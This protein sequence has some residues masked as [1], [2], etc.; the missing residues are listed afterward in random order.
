M[1]FNDELIWYENY[2]GERVKWENYGNSINF[3]MYTD[4]L[5]RFRSF[6]IKS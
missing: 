4:H 1:N 6:S 5:I 3:S 2:Q